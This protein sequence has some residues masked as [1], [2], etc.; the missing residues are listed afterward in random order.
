[1]EAWVA[2]KDFCSCMQHAVAGIIEVLL[3]I[4]INGVIQ[5][6]M[7][8]LL[9][10]LLRDDHI[11]ALP[12]QMHMGDLM[13]NVFFVALFPEGLEA[14]QWCDICVHHEQEGLDIKERLKWTCG[15]AA[16][17]RANYMLSA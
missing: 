13:D 7:L 2:V 12:V 8:T 10:D 16:A 15:L 1:M 14:R 4:C 9:R 6:N 11:L 17:I 5:E 3:R